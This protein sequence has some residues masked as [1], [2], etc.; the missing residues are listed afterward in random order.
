MDADD[1]FRALKAQ[2]F[3]PVRIYVSDGSHY[4]VKHPDQA[5]LDRR[6]IYVGMGG[7]GEGPF[8]RIAIV[9]NI[10][11]TRLEPLNNR[12]RRR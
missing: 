11:V 1:L 5:I 3:K 6:A 9:A 12:R 7:R 4:D 10:H 2:P 8:Q